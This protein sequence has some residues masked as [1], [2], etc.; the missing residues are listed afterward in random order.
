[1]SINFDVDMY[2][3]VN[4]NY[5]EKIVQIKKLF[6]IWSKRN[7]TGK[8]TVVKTLILPVLNHLIITFPNP[9]QDIL[10][11]VNELIFYLYMEFTCAQS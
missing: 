9:A 7:L 3:F 1:M 4:I 6:K 2:K 5:N 11:K 8:I 10:Q